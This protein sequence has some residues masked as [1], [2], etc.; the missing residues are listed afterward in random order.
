MSERR[1]YRYC[2]PESQPHRVRDHECSLSAQNAM[3]VIQKAWSSGRFHLGTH[4]KERC[5]GRGID[6]L[7]VENL[8]RNGGLR[9]APE[10]CPE[11][12][13]WKYRVVGV[14][15]ERYL[16]VVIALDPTEDYAESPLAILITAYEHKPGSK[17]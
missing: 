1:Q 5:S 12:K 14:I 10:H 13:N 8:I 4:F 2:G 16:E 3:G 15:D 7:D 11:Y 6:M 9:S 17:P